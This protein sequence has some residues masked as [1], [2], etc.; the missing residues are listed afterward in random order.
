MLL[1]ENQG[2]AGAEGLPSLLQYIDERHLGLPS[3]RGRVTGATK[4][5]IFHSH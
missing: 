4:D 5:S 2:V 3:D 1:A